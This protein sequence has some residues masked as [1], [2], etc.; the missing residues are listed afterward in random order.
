MRGIIFC[1]SID[2]GN[3]QLLDMTERYKLMNIATQVKMMKNG[4]TLEC[5]NGDFWSVKSASHHALGARCNIAYIERSIDLDTYNHI[6]APCL[7]SYPYSAVRL[8]GEGNLHIDDCPM[9]PF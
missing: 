2:K 1:K 3:Q 6:I 8:W 9:L 7:T 4:F 5:A